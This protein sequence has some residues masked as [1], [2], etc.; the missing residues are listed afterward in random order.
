MTRKLGVK[1]LLPWKFNEIRKVSKA[2]I[3]VERK[4]L[5][6]ECVPCIFRYAFLENLTIANLYT[7]SILPGSKS[8]III[9]VLC[10]FMFDVRIILS[11]NLFD[12]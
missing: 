1:K 7:G 9:I 10:M 12:I 3:G 8:K 2:I 5:R 6:E 4:V 11:C